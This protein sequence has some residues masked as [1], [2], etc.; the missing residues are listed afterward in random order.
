M[1]SNLSVLLKKYSVPLIFF[2]LGLFILIF[3]AM[4]GQGTMF[5]MASVL[6]FIAGGLSIV[7][8]TG[9]I[10]SGMVYVFGIAA[11]I[12]GVITLVM[13]YQSVK[14]TATYN[15]NY[16]KCKSQAKQNL[17]DIRFIQKAYASENGKYI[18]DW[19]ELIDFAKNGTIPFVDAQG[20]VPSRKITPEENKFLYTNNPP[21][22]NN[23]T[24]K[25][26]F[27][28]SKWQEGPNWEKDFKTFKRDTIQ[29]SLYKT[30]FQ[31]KAY[32]A[33][34]E[35][36]GFKPFSADSLPY[37]PFTGGRQKWTLEVKDSVQVGEAFAPAIK[38]SGM[39]PFADIQGKNDDQEEMYFG[40]LTTNDTS[41][42]WESE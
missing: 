9:S 26:A 8:S 19:S 37:I 27:L 17:E 31:G 36:A 39:I 11:G 7:Y 41:G 10:K 4:N 28:L 14:D 3:G 2:I 22:D 30:K 33:S 25:E 6:M 21:I 35:K 13:S 20:V 1:T 5:M 38:V 34:R 23:M 40:T 18:A 15:E 24:E 42:S 32:M 12:A 29:V 16:K